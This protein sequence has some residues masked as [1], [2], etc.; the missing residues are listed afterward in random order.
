MGQVKFCSGFGASEVA[1]GPRGVIF[2]VNV[3]Y[4]FL[5]YLVKTGVQAVPGQA[6]A[7]LIDFHAE[8]WLNR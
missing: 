4:L 5:H 2:S 3:C 7:T 8:P 1:V 6:A